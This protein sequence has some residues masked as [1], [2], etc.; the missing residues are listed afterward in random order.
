MQNKLRA[1]I[2][3]HPASERRAVRERLA[4]ACDVSEPA[5]RHWANGIR[6]LPA[7]QVPTLSRETGIPCD[8]LMRF[9]W[10]NGATLSQPPQPAE[11]SAG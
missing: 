4:K 1:W 3:Q 7:K 10:A 5:V 2:D 6:P 11:A 8:D 9:I